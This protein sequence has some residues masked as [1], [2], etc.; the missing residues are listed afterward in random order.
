MQN[1][2]E[3]G[4]I[5]DPEKPE[6]TVLRHAFTRIWSIDDYLSSSATV[7]HWLALKN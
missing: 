5:V 6:P 7:L 2:L 3:P 1:I 4:E